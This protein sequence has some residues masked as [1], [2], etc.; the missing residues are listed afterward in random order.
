MGGILTPK[1]DIDLS[2]TKIINLANGKILNGKIQ[3]WE[4]PREVKEEKAQTKQ[5]M[6]PEKTTH[7]VRGGL[8]ET[9]CGENRHSTPFSKLFINP[10]LTWGLILT[11]EKP[12]HSIYHLADFTPS[13][14]GF[15]GLVG[16]GSKVVVMKTIGDIVELGPG[17]ELY[18]GL[19]IPEN[20][21]AGSLAGY[22]NSR[23]TLEPGTSILWHGMKISPKDKTAVS[24]ILSYKDGKHQ[25]DNTQGGDL[26]IVSQ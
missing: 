4:N 3:L 25:I 24:F 8:I 17:T 5:V 16:K 10:F 2:H 13:K 15:F 14:E 6:F 20:I 12:E 11:V 19:N 9:S 18:V 21:V 1:S 23:V 22:P 7:I 26:N